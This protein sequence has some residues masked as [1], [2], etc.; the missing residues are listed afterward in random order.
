[1]KL[2]TEILSRLL[3]FRSES[4]ATL[5]EYGVALIVVIIVGGV[6]ISALGTAVSNEIQNTASAF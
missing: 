3:T 5:A 4:G 6:A 2:Y 1:M